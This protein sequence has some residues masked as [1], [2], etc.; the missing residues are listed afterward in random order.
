MVRLISN[1]QVEITQTY[2]G[3][4]SLNG[5]IDIYIK[6]LIL[7]FQGGFNSLNGAIDINEELKNL[8]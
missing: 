3:F 2:F 8:L 7:S 5:A 6:Y 1:S 4:N